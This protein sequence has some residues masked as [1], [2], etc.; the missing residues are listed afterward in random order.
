MSRGWPPQEQVLE[1]IAGAGVLLVEDISIN[2]QVMR[3]YLERCRVSVVIAGN[4]REA[5][6]RVRSHPFE[7]VLMDIQMPEMDG[8][9]AT[10]AI[11]DDGRFDDLPIIALT[12]HAMEGDREKCLAAGMN[13]YLSKPVEP[14]RLLQLLKQWIKPGHRRS[15]R[16]GAIERQEREAASALPV[17]L[18]GVALD[19][20]LGKMSDDESLLRELLLRFYDEYQ[21]LADEVVQLLEDGEMEQARQLLHKLKGASSVLD[22]YR[23]YRACTDLGAVVREGRIDTALVAEFRDAM[24]E[25]MGGLACLR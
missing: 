2:Q 8:Y 11:R 13:D 21:P 9:E 17:L 15:G 23:V 20:A 18:P 5:L 7:L 12:A 6:E 19:R 1:D 24:D 25:I 4:G 22:A 3:E 16:S 14:E 10:R